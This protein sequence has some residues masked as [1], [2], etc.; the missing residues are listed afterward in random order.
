MT[1]E[2]GDGLDSLRTKLASETARAD[3]AEAKA[4]SLRIDYDLEAAARSAKAF[5]PAQ[6][7]SLLRPKAALQPAT[8][9]DGELIEGEHNVMV[10]GDDGKPLSPRAAV[11]AL[12]E[13]DGNFFLRPEDLQGADDRKYANES[14]MDRAARLARTD[15]E[16]YRRERMK[17][18]QLRP[19]NGGRK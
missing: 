9:K 17:L 19:R 8:G 6:L 12:R 18:L 4:K 11:E 3:A 5:N 2:Q 7:V 16:A 1:D 14:P 13:T 10:M 15:P